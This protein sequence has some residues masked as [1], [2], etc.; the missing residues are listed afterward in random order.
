MLKEKIKKV[1]HYS[2]DSKEELRS[3]G[4]FIDE[5]KNKKKDEK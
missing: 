2:K 5:S 1:R 4:I 3:L